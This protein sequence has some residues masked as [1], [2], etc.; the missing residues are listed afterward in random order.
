MIIT[1]EQSDFKAVTNYIR[2]SE[3]SAKDDIF[4]ISS[5]DKLY[6][7]E[8]MRTEYEHFRNVIRTI[9]FGMGAVSNCPLGSLRQM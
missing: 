8:I 5:D 7:R 2:K 1:G 9:A 6:W 3:N 4:K